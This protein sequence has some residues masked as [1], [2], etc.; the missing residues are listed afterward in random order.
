[1][2]IFCRTFSTL[3]LSSLLAIVNVAEA[4]I[5]IITDKASSL[6]GITLGEVGKL[7]LAKSKSFSNGNR[8]SVA[9]YAPGTEIRVQFYQKVLQM[10]DSQVNRYWAKRK[11]TRKLKPP[12][13]ISSDVSMKQWVAST[14][15]SLG[16]IDGKSLD[17]SVK[18]LLIIP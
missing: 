7:Y 11:F 15:N 9:D 1:M 10:S 3:V 6:H 17:G 4:E 12:R 13:K 16:Y 2:K 14:P 8:A 5:V 18:V